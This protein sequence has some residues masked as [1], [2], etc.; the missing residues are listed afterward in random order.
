LE[1]ARKAERLIEPIAA[2]PN[3]SASV[4]K[5]QAYILTHLGFEQS[6][7]QNEFE[8]GV[9]SLQRAM[10]ITAALGAKEVRSPEVAALFADAACWQGEILQRLGRED[11]ARV[12]GIEGD[13]IARKVLEKRPDYRLALHAAQVIDLD[14]GQLAFTH[15]D[16]SEALVWSMR[17][18]DISKEMLKRDGDNAASVN[19]ASVVLLMLG[20][21]SWTMGK[22]QESFEYYRQSAQM[23]DRIMQSGAWF[24]LNSLQPTGIL[25][26]RMADS[27]QESAAQALSQEM[28]QKV[29]SIKKGEAS[30]SKMHVFADCAQL[31]TESVIALGASDFN[32]ARTKGAEARRLVQN[33]EPNAPFEGPLKYVC[34]FYA[35]LNEGEAELWLG[36]YA[37]AEHTLQAAVAVRDKYPPGGTDEQRATSLGKVMMALAMIRQGHD[38]DTARLIALEVKFQRDLAARNHGDATQDRELAITL[39][40]QSLTD[41]PHRAAL[42]H[43]A[44][45]L[46]DH[47]PEGQRQ[48]HSTIRWRRL[49]QAGAS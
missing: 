13:R 34:D 43:E 29:A 18:W 48:L 47:L 37:A 46:I 11:E 10:D 33:V 32:A 31:M 21:I 36:D 22:N 24:V 4:R 3:A 49:I 39:F 38:P 27:G 40:V 17:S 26:Q 23:Y 41:K 20:D 19:N 45:N 6:H 28:I 2:A 35:P 30:D 1:T 15:M 9:A 44:L 7:Y 8:S 14:L 25:G 42:Q 12:I 5:T 16:P